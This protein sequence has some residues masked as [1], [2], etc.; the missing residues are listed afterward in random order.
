MADRKYTVCP[1][2]NQ[3]ILAI[4]ARNFKKLFTMKKSILTLLFLISISVGVQAQAAGSPAD[5][6]KV[7]HVID[8]MPQ[9]PGGQ[10]ALRAFLVLNLHYPVVAEKSGVQGRVVMKFTVSRNGSIRNLSAVDCKI[11]DY[12]KRVFNRLTADEQMKLKKACAKGFAKKAAR[13]IRLMPKWEP[14]EADGK[15]IDVAFSLPVGFNLR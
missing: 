7:Y 9:Y 10:G 5:T 1:A 11:T 4:F 6:A 14:A 2:D 8:K 15:K 12:D 3:Q 13:V